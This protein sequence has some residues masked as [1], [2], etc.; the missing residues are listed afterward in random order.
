MALFRRRRR[1]CG[2]GG[3]IDGCGH[4]PAASALDGVPPHPFGRMVASVFSWSGGC[5]LSI[6]AVA[7]SSA[8]SLPCDRRGPPRRVAVFSAA[9]PL[10]CE[11]WILVTHVFI[12]NNKTHSQ[13]QAASPWCD[14][15]SCGSRLNHNPCREGAVSTS[16]CVAGETFVHPSPACSHESTLGLLLPVYFRI[17][18]PIKPRRPCTRRPRKS[19][20]SPM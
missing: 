6:A 16:T 1:R 4:A 11:A 3:N 17:T 14:T 7:S 10:T 18:Y 12:F 20:V 5:V 19:L 2:D 15:L 13:R 8:S 9:C